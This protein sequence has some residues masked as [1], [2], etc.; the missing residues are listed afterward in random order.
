MRDTFE[1]CDEPLAPLL[2]CSVYATRGNMRLPLNRKPATPGSLADKP[3]LR[4]VSRIG[5]LEFAATYDEA[6]PDAPHDYT[7]ELLRHHA[8]S[9]VSPHSECIS[10]RLDAWI[11]D[12]GSSPGGAVTSILSFRAGLKLIALQQLSAQDCARRAGASS[13][14]ARAE[15]RA[16]HGPSDSV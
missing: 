14:A 1:A 3:W 13:A 4:P 6:M 15:E 7:L 8:W 12:S 10:D 5:S 9:W 16:A 2:D 11:S